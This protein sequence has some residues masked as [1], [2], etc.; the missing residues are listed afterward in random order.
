MNWMAPEVLERPYPFLVYKNRRNNSDD[1]D[2]DDDG[3]GSGGGGGGDDDDDDDNSL[4]TYSQQIAIYKLKV[5][6]RIVKNLFYYNFQ[7]LRL[8]FQVA[9]PVVSDRFYSLAKT[10]FSLARYSNIHHL[11][12]SSKC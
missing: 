2:D 4:L 3:G 1:D 12:K 7:G 11:I 6:K 5:E 9:S 8:T 10:N